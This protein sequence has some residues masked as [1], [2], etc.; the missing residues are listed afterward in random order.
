LISYTVNTD[1]NDDWLKQLPSAADELQAAQ[2]AVDF[3]LKT[4][5]VEGGPGSGHYGHAGRP[6]KRGGS[7]ASNV[8]MSIRTGRDAVARQKAASNRKPDRSKADQA[9]EKVKALKGKPLK[10]LTADQQ[11]LLVNYVK[12]AVVRAFKGLGLPA[13]MNP[14]ELLYQAYFYTDKETGM[15]TVLTGVKVTEYFDIAIEGKVYD[16]NHQEVGS[17]SRTF[18]KADSG[19][20]VRHHFFELKETERGQGFGRRFHLNCEE[21]YLQAGVNS[22]SLGADLEVGGY[23]WA[24]MGFDTSQA[25]KRVDLIR[26]FNREYDLS[27][28]ESMPIYKLAAVTLDGLR[29]GK[30]FLLNSRWEGIK[31]LNPDDAGFLAGYL[32]M[33]GEQ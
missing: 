16:G 28:P 14:S 23:A 21:A 20:Q 5:T 26:S 27:L 29:I 19:P 15:Y 9:K 22:V 10:E 13:D 4:A 25:L 18:R 31:Y 32:Y 3:F 12:P 7:V 1:Y 33:T 2:E 8:A 17:F 6:G 11:E 24:R 30:Q